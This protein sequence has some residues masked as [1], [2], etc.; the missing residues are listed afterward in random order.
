MKKWKC[1]VCDY[2]Y[3]EAKEAVPL[4]KLP[5]EWVSVFL[6]PKN[7]MKRSRKLY[8]QNSPLLLKFWS[9]QTYI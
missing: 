9:T 7:W 2:I 3:D 5:E 4:D 6:I 1:S 8:I